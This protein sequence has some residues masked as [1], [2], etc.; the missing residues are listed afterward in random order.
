M[1]NQSPV[2][3]QTDRSDQRVA[4]QAYLL[5]GIQLPKK[6]SCEPPAAEQFRD[7]GPKEK[8]NAAWL[9]KAVIIAREPAVVILLLYKCD[10][11]RTGFLQLIC[12]DH[13]EI[14]AAEN[15]NIGTG[16]PLPE[17]QQFLNLSGG[18][19]TGGPCPDYRERTDAALAA[20]GGKDQPL[21]AQLC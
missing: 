15:E 12:H 5:S 9:K 18:K 2:R 6:N 7:G 17:I 20:A 1:R 21:K 3:E 19:D 13:P 8:R 14:P 4:G 11:M 16:K 10:D